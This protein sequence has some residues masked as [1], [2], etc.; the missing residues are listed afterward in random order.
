MVRFH[1]Y[2]KSF[3]VTGSP[4]VQRPSE[5][6]LKVTVLPPSDSVQL[7]ARLGIG[8][9]PGAGPSLISGSMMFWRMLADVVSVASPGSSEGGS[10]PQLTVIVPPP[11]DLL[12][13]SLE[14]PPQEAAAKASATRSAV[15]PAPQPIFP[16]PDLLIGTPALSLNLSQSYRSTRWPAP[17]GKTRIRVR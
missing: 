16:I 3:A 4:F 8:F 10:V 15:K 1:E 14:A 11:P 2:S 17:F 6:S 7:S 13:L 9:R 12:L 5:R